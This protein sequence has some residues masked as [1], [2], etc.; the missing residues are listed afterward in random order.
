MPREFIDGPTQAI[1]PNRL[2]STFQ[3]A[4]ALHQAG[5]LPLA[6]TLYEQILKMQPRHFDALQCLGTIAVQTR[7]PQRAVE[8]FDQA[9]AV[10]PSYAALYYNRGIALDQLGR[11]E[12]ALASYDR[13]VAIDPRYA[14]AW[15]N[16]GNLLK[17]LGL[18]EAAPSDRI[19]ATRGI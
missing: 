13:A 18:F 5:Q 7:D 15:F 12:A 4:L 14:D 8:L 16:R 11:F 2:A 17:N 19:A 3:R 6:Q 9:A 10:N 1:T